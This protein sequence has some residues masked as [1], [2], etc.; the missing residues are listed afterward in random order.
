MHCIALLCQCVNT[1]QVL[2]WCHCCCHYLS[3][4]NIRVWNC[5]SPE[6][7][8]YYEW[9]FTM[10]KNHVSTWSLLQICIFKCAIH[11]LGRC[12]R[13]YTWRCGGVKLAA[14]WW[15]GG[16]RWWL[17][18]MRVQFQYEFLLLRADLQVLILL[19]SVISYNI[20]LFSHIL[21]WQ[22]QYILLYWE[23]SMLDL[24]HDSVRVN[25]KEC[26]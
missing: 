12:C 6:T 1:I 19:V 26:L 22:W 5:A 25:F 14:W 7:C 10:P 24:C 3:L 20:S 8:R 11:I 18:N 23:N 16:C 21:S 13:H 15:S 17:C 9:R 2:H 4:A